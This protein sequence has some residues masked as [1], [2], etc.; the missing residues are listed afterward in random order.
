M[1][2]E[3]AIVSIFPQ[4]EPF[5][6]SGNSEKVLLFI[7]GFTASPSEVY[8][9]ARLLHEKTG[10]TSI[11]MLLPGH[12]S[13]PKELNQTGWHDWFEAGEKQLLE[14]INQHA[15]V[16]VIG[17]SLG[18]LLALYAAQEIKGLSGVV[19]INAPIY[20]QFR[21]LTASASVM[22]YIKPYYPKTN[23]KTE[24]LR[25]Q[26]RFAYDVT[27][28]KAFRSMMRLRNRVIKGLGKIDIPVFIMQSLKDES[29][30]PRSAKFIM[31]R[32]NGS[33]AKLVE[34]ENS[35][36]VATMGIEKEKIAAEIAGFIK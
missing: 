27:P 9:I 8:P 2:K 21:F 32:I 36:H 11:G 31:D 34:L 17:L 16:F 23:R 20:T 33:N 25:E 14:L 22:R 28:I 6:L 29:V 26:G 5:W 4:V 15:Q 1:K 13:T 12:G 30:N 24:F 7:H 19:A 10:Y 18:G 35:E 3:V